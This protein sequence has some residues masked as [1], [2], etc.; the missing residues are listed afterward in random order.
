MK[1]HFFSKLIIFFIF[2]TGLTVLSSCNNKN[3][4]SISFER[5]PTPTTASILGSEIHTILLDDSVDIEG[6]I[7]FQIENNG[8]YNIAIWN[9]NSKELIKIVEEGDN[10]EPSFSP[11]GNKIIFSCKSV[12]SQ[13]YQ[14]C[15]YDLL[16]EKQEMLFES[17]Y[18]K[19]GAQWSPD[20][21][22]I[23]FVSSEKPYAHLQVLSLS[24]MQV[25]DLFPNSTSNQSAP[26]WGDDSNTIYFIDDEKGFNIYEGTSNSVDSGKL[27]DFGLD[28]RP[29]INSSNTHIVFRRLYKNNS[30]FDGNEIFLLDLSNNDQIQITDDEIGQDWPIFSPDG[31][32]ILFSS[33]LDTIP[34]LRIM[35]INNRIIYSIRENELEGIAGDWAE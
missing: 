16:L 11:D 13:F 6:K 19:W 17:D 23:I 18:D 14:L 29:D 5:T 33:T 25:S 15:T 10:R 27:T 30:F 20:E 2:L 35:D 21:E 1:S 4:N 24:D 3:E 8:L 26:K 28:D 31:N 7:V 12:S 34:I 22:S 32:F 9:F